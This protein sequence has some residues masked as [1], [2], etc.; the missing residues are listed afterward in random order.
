MNLLIVISLL[1]ELAMAAPAMAS[2]RIPE[3]EPQTTKEARAYAQKMTREVESELKAGDFLPLAKRYDWAL[4]HIMERAAREL[5]KRGH[6]DLADEATA[7]WN[8]HYRGFLTRMVG[9]GRDIGDHAP[10]FDWLKSFYLKVELVLGREVCKSLHISDLHTLNHGIPVVFKPCSFPMDSVPLT[11][12]MEYQ[13]HFNGDFAPQGFY[14][15]LPV[16]VYWVIDIPCMVGTAGL[17][18]LLCGPAASVGEY[19][20]YRTIGPKISN[21]IFD[22]VCGQEEK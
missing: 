20:T 17:A 19:L 15:V 4:D 8:F 14:G 7:T 3:R 10:L 5:K 1:L 11:R 13:Q 2:D 6:H 21:R 18:A 16:L 9:E 12:K 22:R